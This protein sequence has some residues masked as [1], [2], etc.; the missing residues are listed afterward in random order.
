MTVIGNEYDNT[1][2][3]EKEFGI[4][5]LGDVNND[6]TVDYIDFSIVDAFCRAGF[7][8]SYSFR[9]CDLNCDGAVNVIDRFITKLILK[10]SFGRNSVGIACPCR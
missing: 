8:E 1:A 3:V 6:S 10:G 4:A 9:D 2:T 5:L 7:A